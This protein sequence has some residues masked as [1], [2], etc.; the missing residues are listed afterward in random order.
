MESKNFNLYF[1]FVEIGRKMVENKWLLEWN[2]F[3]ISAI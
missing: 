3:V 2:L 1:S